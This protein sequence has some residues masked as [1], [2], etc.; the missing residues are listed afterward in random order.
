ATALWPMSTQDP[1][2]SAQPPEPSPSFPLM[3]GV[4]DHQ[5]QPGGTLEARDI[6]ATNVVS[7][8]QYIHQQT[9]YQGAGNPSLPANSSASRPFMGFSLP[10][11]FTRRERE[12]RTL[13]DKFLD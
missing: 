11:H 4:P 13:V 10:L 6:Y 5:T 1:E 7:G 12:H 2:P 8:S 3:Q 9:I